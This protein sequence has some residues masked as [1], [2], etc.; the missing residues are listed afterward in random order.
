[1]STEKILGIDQSL[2]STG[3]CLHTIA[4]NSTKESHKYKYWIIPSKMTEKMK[5]FSHKYISLLPYEKQIGE[6]YTSKETAKTHNIYDI[7]KTIESIIKKEKPNMICMEGISYG[8]VGGASV[9]DLAGL[10]YCI[11]MLAIEYGIIL[12]LV[13]PKTLKKIATGNAG[14]LKDEMIWAWQQCDPNIKNV[15]DIKVDDLADA[16]FLSRCN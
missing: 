12:Q 16:Y 7:C 8:S 13:P 1:M 15:K 14:A 9:I 2:N 10:N 6:D 3:V 4:I 5:K 11:R